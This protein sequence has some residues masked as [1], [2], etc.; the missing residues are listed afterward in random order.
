[1]SSNGGLEVYLD[2]ALIRQKNLDGATV[3]RAAAETVLA[4]PHISRVY[5]RDQLLNGE[6]APDEIG[7]DIANGF[8]ARRS[9]DLLVVTDPYYI[10]GEGSG[11][12][13]GSPFGYDTHVPLI[14]FGP[15]I[16]RGSYHQPVSVTDVAPTLAAIF[17]VETPS[18]ASGRVLDEIFE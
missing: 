4:M 10:F 12:T 3:R 11:T 7:R 13:H 16:K 6:F 17:G 14:F 15:H 5:T 2:D 8:F 1:V 9:G 18:G